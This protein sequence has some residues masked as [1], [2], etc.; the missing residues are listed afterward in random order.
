MD[1]VG[2]CFFHKPVKPWSDCALLPQTHILQLGKLKE[3]VEPAAN[4]THCAVSF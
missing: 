2:F 3:A 1:Q 4:D